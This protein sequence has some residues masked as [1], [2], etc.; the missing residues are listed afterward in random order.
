MDDKAD[1]AA[2]EG[3]EVVT[4]LG[5]RHRATGGLLKQAGQSCPVEQCGGLGVLLAGLVEIDGRVEQGSLWREYSG[6]EAGILRFGP[7][8]AGSEGCRD[9]HEHDSK[10]K[11]SRE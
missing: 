3:I 7:L 11:Q 4:H 1:F 9:S 6:V 8:G 5:V 10:N 2:K